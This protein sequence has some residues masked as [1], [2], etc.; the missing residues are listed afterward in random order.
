MY[1]SKTK[2][3][4]LHGIRYCSYIFSCVSHTGACLVDGKVYKVGETWKKSCSLTCVCEDG[5]R[6]IARCFDE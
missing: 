5:H 6:G 1:V 2:E 3:S 4:L